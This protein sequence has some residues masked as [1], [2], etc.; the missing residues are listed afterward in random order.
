VP[1]AWVYMTGFA[2]PDGAAHFRDDVYGLDAEPAL[3]P[4]G[5]TIE[6]LITSSIAPR[7]A[8]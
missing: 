3:T 5:P 1:V 8:F 2:T 6:D 7:R 4:P